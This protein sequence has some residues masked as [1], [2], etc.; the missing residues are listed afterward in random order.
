[1]LYEIIL[2]FYIRILIFDFCAH[3]KKI[4]KMRRHIV[5]NSAKRLPPLGIGEQLSRHRHPFMPPGKKKDKS[6]NSP[7]ETNSRTCCM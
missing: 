2:Q 1:M 3:G 7:T 6:I 5:I 4:S